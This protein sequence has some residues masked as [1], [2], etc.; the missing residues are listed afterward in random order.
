MEFTGVYIPED[1][2]DN[3]LSYNT[4]PYCRGASRYLDIAEK[5]MTRY[6]IERLKAQYWDLSQCV[7]EKDWE[8][9]TFSRKYWRRMWY[10]DE[11]LFVHLFQNKMFQSAIY[12]RSYGRHHGYMSVLITLIGR[13]PPHERDEVGRQLKRVSSDFARAV[14]S[15]LRQRRESE[16]AWERLIIDRQ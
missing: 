15:L 8:S 16:K 9:V 12:M 10:W 1:I 13:A 4:L 5:R 14:D 2:I 6:R 3:I 11:D 7:H